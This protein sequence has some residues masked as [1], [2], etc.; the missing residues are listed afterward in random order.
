MR[1]PI[2]LFRL[3]LGWLLGRRLLLLETIGRKSGARRFT[4]LEISL[5]DPP[6]TWYLAS[7]WGPSSDWL[8]NLS[9]H[10][11]ATITIGVRR[12]QCM[13]ELLDPD[14]SAAM[15][16][17]YSRE[18]PHLALTLAKAVGWD[19]DDHTPDWHRLGREGVPWVRLTQ[20]T[21]N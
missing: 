11:S 7:G 12:I 21:E 3:R 1:S 9:T 15:M 4:V 19:I 2:P 20:R 14:E 5:R 10:P 8:Q 18:H 17:R 16:L 13:A 6:D